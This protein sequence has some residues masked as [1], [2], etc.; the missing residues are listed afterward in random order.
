M[1]SFLIATLVTFSTIACAKEEVVVTPVSAPQSVQ[2]AEAKTEEKKTKRVCLD[3][4]TK[5]GKVIMGK[6]GKPQQVCKD[7]KIHKKLEGTKVPPK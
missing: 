5:D 3:K 7:V 2:V 6:D 1:K 4:L